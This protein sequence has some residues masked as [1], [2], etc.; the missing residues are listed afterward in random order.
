MAS[1]AYPHLI[2]DA[3]VREVSFGLRACHDNRRQFNF[4]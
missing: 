1:R 2:G 3:T 4:D